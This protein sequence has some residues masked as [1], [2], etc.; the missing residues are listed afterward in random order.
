MKKQRPEQKSLMTPEEAREFVKKYNL[1]DISGIHEAVKSIFK[2]ALQAALEAEMD[3]ELGYSKYDWKNK[4]TGNSRNGHTTKNV[5]T[6][7]GEVGLKMPRDVEGE[8][9]PKL[10]PKHARQVDNRIEEIVIGMYSIGVSNKEITGQLNEIYGID[11]SAEMISRITDKVLPLA[12]EWKSRPL[13]PLYPIIFLDGIVFHVNQDGTVVKKTVYLVLAVTL[14][15]RKDILSIWIGES[16]SAKFWMGVLADLKNRGVKDIFIAAVDGLKGF[17]EAI[18]AVFP[19]TDVQQCIVHQV[20]TSTKFVSYKDLDAFC[21]GLK[22]IY[23]APT[24]KAALEQLDEFEGT[25]GRKYPYAIKSWRDNWHRL[26]TFFKYP[27][28]VRRLIYTTNPIEG[29]NRRIRKV[30][31]TK[32]SFTSDDALL[33]LLYLV[34]MDIIEKWKMPTHNWIAI[35]N[36]LRIHY[37]ERLEP[38]LA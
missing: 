23:T 31:K 26:A 10:V 27:D 28:D 30:T 25:W 3:H 16:E 24:E 32:G 5:R 21:Q 13:D 15:G 37:G 2:D 9:D 8:F 36:Q 33:K 20:R 6:T 11:V 17:E 7:Y 29:V 14:D 1:R 22:K 38:Y 34:A 4:E 19:K 35:I 12:R 18:T